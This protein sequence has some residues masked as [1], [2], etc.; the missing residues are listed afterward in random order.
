MIEAMT[1][2]GFKPRG[3]LFVPEDALS[4]DPVVLRYVRGFVEKI[5]TLKEGGEYSVGNVV[6]NTPVRHIHGVETYGLNLRSDKISIS[7]IVDT[8]YFDGLE[9]YY[10]GDIVVLNLVRHQLKAKDELDHLDV[11]DAERIIGSIRPKVAIITH[12]GMT[13]LRA[14]PWE[15]AAGIGERLGVKVIAARDG[16]EFN[17]DEVYSQ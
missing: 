11:A 3:Y 14:K 7:F 12:F 8:R 6:F 2:G 13:M 5:E 10:N 1:D 15:I 4:D 17:I 16:M 9:T